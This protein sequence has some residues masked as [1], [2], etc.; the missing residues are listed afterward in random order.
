MSHNLRIRKIIGTLAILLPVLLIVFNVVYDEK[1]IQSSISHYYYTP[2]IGV[3]ATV[4]GFIALFLILY[5]GYDR[6]DQVACVIAGATAVGIILFPTSP[7]ED[8]LFGWGIDTNTLH[9]IFSGIFFVDLAVISLFLF[10]KSMGYKTVQKRKRNRVYRV[11]GVVI[12]S[13]VLAIASTHRVGFYWLTFWLEWIGI[14]AFGVAWLV[15]G[16][17]VLKDKL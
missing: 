9:F 3:F 12:L 4:L 7:N 8:S 1:A 13:V 11:C 15:K 14:L 6:Y 5:K 17:A 16:E 10:T 2:A